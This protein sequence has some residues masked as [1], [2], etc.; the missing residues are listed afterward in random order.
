MSAW[1]WHSQSP[2]STQQ[3][4]RSLA[5]VANPR[6]LVVALIGP[7]GAGKTT[8]SKGLAEGL[9][10]DPGVVASPTFVIAHQHPAPEG[11]WKGLNHADL[12][13]VKNLEEL[14]A[15]GFSDMLERGALVAVEWADRVPEALTK[16]RLEI[17]FERPDPT[18]QPSL[19]VLNAVAFGAVSKAALAAWQGAMP[20]AEAP[21]PSESAET[22][23]TTPSLET[24]EGADASEDSPDSG[25]S[26]NPEIS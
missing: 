24:S 1:R 26:E 10:I 19:R 17:T 2:D 21:V 20:E 22:P 9:G 13:R 15:T 25:E 5:E 14:E 6:G 16:D 11:P 7:L 23:A 12:Y 18:S 4:A 8:F 3:A